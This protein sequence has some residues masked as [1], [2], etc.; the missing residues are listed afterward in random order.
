[1]KIYIYEDVKTA[2]MVSDEPART[3]DP[4]CRIAT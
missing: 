3:G 1:M 2:K 4:W